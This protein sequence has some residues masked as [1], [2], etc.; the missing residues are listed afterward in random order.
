[1]R[2]CRPAISFWITISGVSCSTASASLLIAPAKKSTEV[3][4]NTMGTVYSDQGN[5]F[6]F[7]TQQRRKSEI[8]EIPMSFD[9][10]HIYFVSHRALRAHRAAQSSQRHRVFSLSALS[11][12]SSQPRAS[13]LPHFPA[14]QFSHISP[15][16][17]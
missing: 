15:I 12:L 10:F 2:S 6:P 4:I 11:S 13:P 5:V 1:M 16:I 8:Q 3:I 7:P 9:P 14:S 17:T